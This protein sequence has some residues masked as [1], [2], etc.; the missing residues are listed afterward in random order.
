MFEDE[1]HHAVD[2]GHD[3][4]DAV[5]VGAG[6]PGAVRQVLHG[7]GPVQAGGRLAVGQPAEAAVVVVLA[8]LEDEVLV[9]G[10]VD[11]SSAARRGKNRGQRLVGALDALVGG[12]ARGKRRSTPTVNVRGRGNL[13]HHRRR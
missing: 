13:G 2:L 7:S 3:R 6:Q 12:L 9:D 5:V 1:L 10:P 11:A 8:Q 4:F